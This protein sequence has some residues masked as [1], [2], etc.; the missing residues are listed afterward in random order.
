VHVCSEGE[1][2]PGAGEWRKKET[3][4]EDDMPGCMWLQLVTSKEGGVGGLWELEGC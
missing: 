2:I 4:R 1:A 3:V